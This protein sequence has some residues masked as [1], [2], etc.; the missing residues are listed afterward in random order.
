M[1]LV[2][3]SGLSGSGK[4]VALH[5]L[6]DAGYYCVDNLP[7]IMLTVLVRMLKEEKIRKVAVAIDARSGHG[8]ELLPEKLRLLGEEGTRQIFLFL[9]ADD[10]TLL[11]R[12]SE[13]RRRHP[14]AADGQSLEEAIRTE[15]ELLAP[16]S[17]LGHRIDTSGL[18]ANALREWVRQFID[19]EP[20]QGLTLMFESFGFKHGIP[21]DAD[22]VFDARC[23]PN[24][25]YDPELRPLTGKDR[26]VVDFLEAEEEV[27]RMRDDIQRFI[28]T[29]LPAYVRDNRNYLTVA[30]G[31][32]GGQHRSVYLAEWL[33]RAFA[34]QARV[35]IRHRT[36]AGG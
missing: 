17:T 31:C 8:I 16:I 12:Y 13:S 35:L 11:K 7:V 34:G 4:S 9:H 33:G 2:L 21:L 32:T 29:W 19:A 14:L 5:L 25:H 36:L 6:E 1:E 18:K 26:P 28:A 3:I 10:E 30:I 24:P 15:R 22:L 27:I 23:L 20:G